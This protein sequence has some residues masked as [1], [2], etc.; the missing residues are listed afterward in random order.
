MS[1]FFVF[2]AA[3]VNPPSWF[4]TSGYPV[5]NYF[6]DGDANA[7]PNVR[8]AI[9]TQ[10]IGLMKSPLVPPPFCLFNPQ[11]TEENIKL[12]VG[13]S[14]ITNVKDIYLNSWKWK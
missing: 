10:F 13:A 1:S 2:Y 12:C 14:G 7:D 4:K 5:G 8:D 11:C 6:F 9:K 3:Q